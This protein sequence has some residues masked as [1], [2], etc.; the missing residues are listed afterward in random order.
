MKPSP[1]KNFVYNLVYQVLAMIIP[2]LTA[3]YLAR[4]LGA[5]GIGTYSYTHSIVYYFML[6]T[7]LGINNYGNRTIA[8]VRDDKEKLSKTF[9]SIYSLQLCVGTIMLLLYLGYVA[10][11]ENQYPI[12]SMIQSLF[13]VSAILDI[14]WLFFGLEEF[15]KTVTRNS[16]VKLCNVVFIFLFVKD[17]SDVWK[18]TLIMSGMT[19]ISQLVLWGFARKKIKFV[20]IKIRDIKAHIKPNLILF[21]PVIAVSLYKMMDKIMLGSISG[22]TEVGFYENAEKITSIPLMLITALGTVMLPRMSNIIAKGNTK[23]AS[24]YI[25]KSISFVMFAS[26]AMFAGLAA[27]GRNFAPLFFGEEFRKTGTLIMMLSSTLPMISFANVLRTQFLIP[28]EKD[29]IYIKSVFLGAA[30]N[31]IMNLIFIPPY[32]SIGAC[33]GTI[34][35]EFIVM[36]YQAFAIRNELPIRQYLKQSL[37]FLI[38]AIIMLG[39][40]Y[41]LNL[42][43]LNPYVRLAAQILAGIVISSLLNFRYI[44][45]LLNLKKLKFSRPPRH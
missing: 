1:K 34:A 15:K 32:G 11:L 45:S 28:K 6:L 40:I 13:I 42:V 9:W 5:A 24:T 17:S 18:Y 31:L 38:K 10:L 43:N 2:I 12:I 4:T 29:K 30:I 7:M 25:S 41:P 14:N 8:K 39:F 16:I 3:P 44:S 37:P 20:L 36:A 19:C 23:Q 35:A 26:L 21:I 27:V 22:M 33:F